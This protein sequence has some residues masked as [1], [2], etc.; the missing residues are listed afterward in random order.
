MTSTHASKQYLNS[1]PASLRES[2]FP[3]ATRQDNFVHGKP[4]KGRNE[5]SA[6]GGVAWVI[7]ELNSGVPFEKVTEKAWKNTVELFGLEELVEP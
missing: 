3:L 6:I 7:H 1:L 4:V 2:Y 5:P